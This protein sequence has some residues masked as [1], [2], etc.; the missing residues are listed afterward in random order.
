MEKAYE[1]TIKK[2]E[3]DAKEMNAKVWIE[4]SNQN[5]QAREVEG[6]II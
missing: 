4:Q 3:K 5:Y 6:M 1:E 2:I